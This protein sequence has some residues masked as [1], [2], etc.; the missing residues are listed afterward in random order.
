MQFPTAKFIMIFLNFKQQMQQAK[1][2]LR[3]VKNASS[4]NKHR[5]NFPQLKKKS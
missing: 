3:N 4:E 2:E 1:R 5:N